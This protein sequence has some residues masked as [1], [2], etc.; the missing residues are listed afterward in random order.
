M[1]SNKA[2]RI[3]MEWSKDFRQVEDHEQAGFW[4]ALSLAF[5]SGKTKVIGE[6][7]QSAIDHCKHGISIHKEARAVIASMYGEEAVKHLD[8]QHQERI[9]MLEKLEGLVDVQSRV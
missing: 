9:F 6:G 1:K 3:C 5:K 8:D 2:A 4:I 7:L